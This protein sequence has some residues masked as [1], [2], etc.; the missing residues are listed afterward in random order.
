MNQVPWPHDLDESIHGPSLGVIHHVS[1]W[2][3]AEIKKPIF[4]TWGERAMELRGQDLM[5]V[6]R[7]S[8]RGCCL[9]GDETWCSMGVLMFADLFA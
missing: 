4:I 8:D 3:N 9:R 2:G 7:A 1:T 6:H 5:V